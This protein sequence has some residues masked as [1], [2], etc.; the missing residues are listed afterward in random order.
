MHLGCHNGNRLAREKVAIMVDDK[1][2]GPVTVMVMAPKNSRIGPKKPVRVY[3]ALWREHE[4]LTQQQVADR[5]GGSCS[6][7]TVSRWENSV[8]VP[9]LDV[10]AAYAEALH[11]NVGDLYRPPNTGPSLDAM[12][13]N[14]PKE[15]RDH[16][17]SIVAAIASRGR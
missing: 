1:P 17:V 9:T 3:L 14:A 11:R 5:I 6:K 16:V 12:M 13:A 15:I 4:K 2:A 7:S 10:L 8:R